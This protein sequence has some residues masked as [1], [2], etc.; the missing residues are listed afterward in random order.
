[1]AA[2]PNFGVLIFG[3]LVV[4]FGVGLA[5]M[6]VPVYLSKLPALVFFFLKKL[7]SINGTCALI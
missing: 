3:R 5:S 4:G 7:L 6:I 1:M 2:A